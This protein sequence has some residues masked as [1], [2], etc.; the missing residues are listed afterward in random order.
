[1]WGGI[2]GRQ[3][4]SP[5]PVYIGRT[6]TPPSLRAWGTSQG[7][8]TSPSPLKRYRAGSR[9]VSVTPGDIAKV[10]KIQALWRGR[11]ARRGFA[12]LKDM[13]TYVGRNL[14]AFN[15]QSVGEY[16]YLDSEHFIGTGNIS[17]RYGYTSL[18]NSTSAGT[19]PTN[20]IGSKFFMQSLYMNMHIEAKQAQN[21]ASFAPSSYQ[22][23][24]AKKVRILIVYDKNPTATSTYPALNGDILI[25]PSATTAAQKFSLWQ[26]NR[27]NQN[28]FEIVADIR[29]TISM[30]YAV[31]TSSTATTN[32]VAYAYGS[33][34]LDKRIKVKRPTLMKATSVGGNWTDYM[35]G[36][37]LI[38]IVDDSSDDEVTATGT[39]I[40]VNGTCRLFFKP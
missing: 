34:R 26:Y 16:H 21:P 10:T 20:R 2:R 24:P 18:L 37:L 40:G 17:G 33:V 11:R 12:A 32:A 30:N 19:G 39:A 15:Y 22:V 38:Y 9:S 27:D 5:R 36:A 8:F 14:S 23:A 31:P 35:S 1:M 28:R 7:M 4:W 29:R 25:Q 13:S 3:A 6:P